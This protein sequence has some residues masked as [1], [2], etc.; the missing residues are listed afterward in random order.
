MS[1][2]LDLL[3]NLAGTTVEHKHVVPDSDTY[4]LIDPY[5]R[6]IENTTYNKTVLMRG[7]HNSERFTFEVPRYVDGHDMSLCN[8]VIVHFDNVGDSIENVHHDVAYMDDLRINP[9]KPETVISSWLIRREATQIVGILSFSLQYQ[10]VEGDEVTYEWNT[11]SYD[12]IEIRKS[13]NNGEASVIQYTNVLEQWRSQIFGAGDSV[14]ANI[15]NEGTTQVTA[16]KNESA[17]QQAAIELKGSETLATIPE[18][19][20]EVYNMA[21]EAVRTK[22]DGIVC[23]AEGTAIAV[24]DASDD[25][26]RGLNV[27]G[28]STQNT[29]NGYQLFDANACTGVN[30]NESIVVSDDGYTITAV[31]GA[32]V[33]Y[34]FSRFALELDKFLGKTVVLKADSFTGDE[35]CAVILYGFKEGENVL[36]YKLGTTDTKITC[37]ISDSI[38]E[39]KLYIYTNTTGVTL[40]ENNTVIVKGIMLSYEDVAYEPYTGGMVSPNPAYPQ[41]VVSVENPTVNICGKNLLNCS[42]ISLSD[43]SN[44]Y[45]TVY[46]DFTPIVGATYSLSMDV[47]TDVLPFAINIGCGAN[48]YNADMSPKVTA[49]Y[50]ENGRISIVFKWLPTAEQIVMGYTKLY[51]RVPR[52]ASK[53]TFNATVSNIQ[54]ELCDIATVYEPYRDVQSLTLNH[55]L[56]GIPVDVN[57]NYTDEDGQQWICD[58]V[59]LERGV[60]IQRVGVLRLEGS[61]NWT[62]YTSGYGHYG[63]MIW[64]ALNDTYSRS[65]GLCNQLPNVGSKSDNCVW[66][67]VNDDCIYVVTKEWYGKGLDAWKAHLNENTLEITYVHNTPIETPLTAEEIEAYKSIRTN[68]PST[69]VLNNAGAMMKIKYNADTKLYVEKLEA[70]IPIAR[71]GNVTLLASAWEGTNNLYS[72]V[73][74]IDGVT[75]NS[76]VDLTPGIEQLA[77]FYDKDLTF[78]TENVG[79][80]VTVYAIGQKPEN[81]YTIQVTITEVDV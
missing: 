59:D 23:E 74:D 43:F 78:V 46:T 31:G 21:S 80:I 16:V 61:A 18:D 8:R 63:F 34:A 4:F 2:A 56:H 66:V 54:L 28:K 20:T 75:R 52:Y 40:S 12:D 58:E 64:H 70:D 76:Q 62:T 6:Q 50:S 19:Y 25:Y 5:T 9:D 24:A 47:N 10:C 72:Q 73:V 71:I 69:T 60:Y 26:L 42:D 13:K 3:N 79:G 49:S 65:I 38:D 29:T 67:G 51:I 55:T 36:S 48:A 37:D 53:T 32:T 57:G 39:I 35:E 68:Y 44:H 15:T 33:G 17:T 22:A 81:D 30:S 77:I 14:M 11:D 1:Q 41:E 7:D 45:Y 27:Y